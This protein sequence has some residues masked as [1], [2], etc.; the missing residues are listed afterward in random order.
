MPMLKLLTRC[1][2]NAYMGISMLI[3][4]VIKCKIHMMLK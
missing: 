3:E 1:Y 4:I 2:E